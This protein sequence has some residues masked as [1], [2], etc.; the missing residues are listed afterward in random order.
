[1]PRAAK[2]SILPSPRV[3]VLKRRPSGKQAAQETTEVPV[4][5]QV[6]RKKIKEECPLCGKMLTPDSLAR[7][8]MVHYPDWQYKC[9]WPDCPFRNGQMSNVT[10]H[11]SCE[12]SVYRQHCDGCGVW[13]TDPAAMT[14]H[15]CPKRKRKSTKTTNTRATKKRRVVDQEALSYPEGSVSSSLTQDYALPTSD[16]YGSPVAGPSNSSDYTAYSSQLALQPDDARAG[17]LPDLVH[18][19]GLWVEQS[20]P[21][22]DNLRVSTVT[23]VHM[24]APAEAQVQLHDQT[25]DGQYDADAY[26]QQYYNVP[27]PSTQVAEQ[28]FAPPQPE[29]AQF[30]L[31]LNNHLL[32][33]DFIPELDSLNAPQPLWQHDAYAQQQ[34]PV[35]PELQYFHQSPLDQ[36][37]PVLAQDLRLPQPLFLWQNEP[38]AH[39][40][41]PVT[42]ELQYFVQP[43]LAQPIPDGFLPPQPQP[44]FDMQPPPFAFDPAPPALVPQD[45]PTYGL[46]MHGGLLPELPRPEEFSLFPDMPIFPELSE[47]DFHFNYGLSPDF[48]LGAG[49]DE[50]LPLDDWAQGFILPARDSLEPFPRNQHTRQLSTFSTFAFVLYIS[51]RNLASDIRLRIVAFGHFPWIGSNHVLD[52]V[53][54]L[55]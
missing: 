32:N 50:M 35:A 39:P 12:G 51:S 27:G 18:A 46:E 22:F 31:D 11:I 41:L 55:H 4:A 9:P 30:D 13:R 38:Y 43:P 42:P 47:A 40:Q 28:A 6:A 3:N 23:P 49:L 48:G 37:G 53:H 20:T 21:S 44:P 7:H 19:S 1:M 2:V 26:G 10:T 29:F 24:D 33:F 34:L 36:P 16:P 45:E 14:R 25:L 52:R 17:V 15:P 54:S 8:K 5:Q